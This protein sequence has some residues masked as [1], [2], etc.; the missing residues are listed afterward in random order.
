[1]STMTTNG[2]GND[3]VAL[4]PVTLSD[5]ERRC[6]VTIEQ[7]GSYITGAPYTAIDPDTLSALEAREFL[8]PHRERV[9]GPWVYQLTETGRLWLKRCTENTGE[10]ELADELTAMFNSFDE[11]TQWGFAKFA[12]MRLGMELYPETEEVG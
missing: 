1:M 7:L 10:Y 2:S 9:M 3:W 8:A 11:A 5:A 12:A 4:L 6:L